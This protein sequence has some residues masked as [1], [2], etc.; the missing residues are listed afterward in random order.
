MATSSDVALGAVAVLI[1]AAG[2]GARMGGTRKQFRA[3]GGKPVLVQTLLVFERHPEVDYLVVAAPADAVEQLREALVNEGLTK[4]AAV[5]SGGASRQDS[6]G[7]AL[8]AAPEDTGVILVHDAV[9]PFVVPDH[10]STAIAA[11][12]THGAAALAVPV[13]DTLRRGTDGQFGA[14]VPR[15]GLYRMQTPQGCR[16]DWFEQAHARAREH[17]YQATDD[18]DLVQQAGFPVQIIAGS[19]DNIKITTPDDW[20]QAQA[21]FATASS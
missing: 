18:V 6:V 10:I 20:V 12:R 5:V 4:L 8:A 7:C 16:H 15:D 9:R 13:V 21:R 11:V 17:G 2:R 14:T 19:I 1:P 3:L